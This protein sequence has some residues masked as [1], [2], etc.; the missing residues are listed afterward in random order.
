MFAAENDGL[1]VK[2]DVLKA[3]VLDVQQRVRYF[4]QELVQLYFCVVFALVESAFDVVPECV[5]VVLDVGE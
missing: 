3:I 1:R 2:V 4:R 5:L